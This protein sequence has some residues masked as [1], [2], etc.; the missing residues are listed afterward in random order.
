MFSVVSQWFHTLLSWGASVHTNLWRGFYTPATEELHLDPYPIGWLEEQRVFK[1]FENMDA[2]SPVPYQPKLL[3][4]QS[5]RQSHCSASEGQRR[6]PPEQAWS[7][8]VV[9]S[10]STAGMFRDRWFFMMGSGAQL[11]GYTTQARLHLT[12]RTELIQ[13]NWTDDKF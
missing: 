3:L 11:A 12:N 7:Q 5:T 2:A 9:S 10:L 13:S 1:V 8:P 4:L 6:L